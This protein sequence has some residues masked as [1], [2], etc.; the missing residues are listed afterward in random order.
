[1][2]NDATSLAR[3][4]RARR[5]LQSLR[6]RGEATLAELAKDADISRPTANLIVT[7]LE[8]EG[9]I[10]H[11][12]TSSGAGRPAAQYSFAQR[13]GFV[14]ALDIQRDEVTIVA[15]SIAG[16]VLLATVRALAGRGRDERLTELCRHIVDVVAE[17]EPT[18]GNAIRGC[19]S[20]TGIVD[21]DGTILR[22]FVVPQW[23]DLPLAEILTERTGVTFRVDN[24]VN[25]AAFGE[26]TTRVAAKRIDVLDALLYVRVF[27]GFRTGLILGGDIHRG[28]R[29]HAGEINDNLDGEL[30]TSLETEPEHQHWVLRTSTTIGAVSSAIDPTIAVISTAELEDPESAAEVWAHLRAMGL[31]TAPKLDLEPDE[32][33]QAASS[34]GALSLALRDADTHFLHAPTRYPVAATGWEQIIETRQAYADRRKAEAHPRAVVVSEPL[35]IGVVGLGMRSQLARHV[36][37]DRNNAVIVG[38][39]DPDPLA[40]TRVQ[41]LIGKPPEACPVFRTLP[42]LIETGIGAAFITSPDD[43]HEAAAVDLLEVGVPVYLEKPLAT[44]IDASTRILMAAR[45]HRTR[46]YVGHNMRHMSF[47]RQLRQLISD[48]AIG[49]VQ[50]IWC[51]HFVGHGGDYYFKDWHADR[52][53]SNGLLLQK[54][55]HDIDVMHWLAGSEAAEV[56]GMGDLMIYGRNRSRTGQGGALMEDWF[57]LDNWPPES[58]TG[59]NPVVDVEDVSMLLMRMR[60]GV[61]VSYQQ[62]HFSPDYWRNYTIIGS[63]GRLENFGDGEGGVIR[64]WNRRGFYN[65]E[66]DEQFPIQGDRDGHDDAD[67]LTVAEFLRFARTGAPTDTS[68]VGAWYA[69]V[70]GIQA[71]ESLREGST[72]KR[73]PSLPPELRDYFLSNQQG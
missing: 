21:G 6:T 28:H 2:G 47:V 15:A 61:L 41:Q 34:I 36:E 63:R 73:I 53:R 64:L 43:T 30:R 1:M 31:P 27:A 66:G 45:E 52:R 67:A 44:T 24:D 7:D 29:W 57:S 71:T 4:E 48:G 9:L 17:L 13:H 65:A 40:A 51:R 68:P 23:Q 22:S 54:A 10:V 11:G 46:L 42:E 55:V 8:A 70:S 16:K 69:V 25:C 37:S 60:S 5:V 35:R 62:C 72:P 39:Y 19:A 50:T 3:A 33:G 59:L 26:F 38:A 14:I 18:H 12:S 49:D 32:L 56:V 20:T 58:L